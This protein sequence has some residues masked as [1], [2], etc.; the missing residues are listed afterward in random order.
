MLPR[1]RT[2]W[3]A[4]VGAV[5]RSRITVRIPNPIPPVP[6][7][8]ELPWAREHV[9]ERL[10]ETMA[11][12]GLTQLPECDVDNAVTTL[13]HV[14]QV[15]DRRLRF[16]RSPADLISTAPPELR[17]VVA[18]SLAITGHNVHPLAKLRLGFDAKDSA[19][20]GPENFRPTNLKLIG[21]HPNLLAE[22]GDVTAIPAGRVS[23]EYAE[24]YAAHCSRP[25]VAVGTCDRCGIRPGDRRRHDHGYGGNAAGA[26]HA[27]AP[28]R[29][30]VP[31]GNVRAPSVH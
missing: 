10:T 26:A 31:F 2:G 4:V 16:Y 30:D 7:V 19:L 5:D 13:A 6:L 17:G 15:I 8:D 9:S 11:V 24:H 18:D 14:K 28:N 1:K 3:H 12:E 27:V 23:R 29:P 25:P 22:T 20:Y 21:V